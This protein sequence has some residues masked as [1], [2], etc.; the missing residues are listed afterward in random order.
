MSFPRVLLL[1]GHG[2]VSL[3]MTSHLV[4]RSWNVTSLIR[5][6]SQEADIL[7]QGKVGPGKVSVFV[8]SLADVKSEKDA[9]KILDSVKP[10]YV[11]WSAGKNSCPNIHGDASV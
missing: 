10:D 1:G 8:S 7:A 6:A 11:I 4:A 9:Q 2:K 5:S 3:F